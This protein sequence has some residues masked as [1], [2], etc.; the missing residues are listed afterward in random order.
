MSLPR[1]E[2]GLTLGRLWLVLIL[3]WRDVMGPN[4]SDVYHEGDKSSLAKTSTLV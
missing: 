1:M 3:H 2:K 4:S